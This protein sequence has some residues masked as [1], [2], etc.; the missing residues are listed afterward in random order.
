MAVRS[1]GRH[2]TRFGQLA[3]AGLA[4]RPVSEL[5]F[6]VMST[7]QDLPMLDRLLDALGRDGREFEL[8]CRWFLQNDPEFAAEYQHVWLWAEWPGRWGPDRGIDLVAQTFAGRIDAVQAKHYA[9]DHSVT[10][11]DLDTFLSESNRAGVGARLLIASTDLIAR[12]AREV[13]AEQEKPVSTCLLSRLRE[14]AVRWP[15]SIG[16]LVPAP[17]PATQPHAHQ[18]IA[19][20][21][22]DRWAETTNARGRVIMACGTGKTLIE[23]WAAERL[24]A[25]HVLVLAPTIPLLRQFAREWCRHAVTRRQ[26]LRIC[27]DKAADDT[28]DII[29]GDE[30]SASRTT[31]PAE[32]AE[33]LRQPAPQLVL[34]TYDSSPVLAEAL[35]SVTEFSFDLAI[36]DEAHRCA[37]LE[38]SRH[39]T[40]LEENAIRA[41]RRLFFTATPT[42]Y[43]TRDK[44]RAAHKNVRLA[45]MD[46]RTRFGPVIHHLSFAD[47]IAQ[48]LLCRYQVAVIPI[49]DDEVH[50]LIRRR[51]IVTADGDQK[52]EA[53][54]LATQIACARAMRRFGCRRIVAFHPS[55]ADSKRFSDHFPT[56]AGL[57]PEQERPPGPIWSQHIDGAGMPYAKRMRLLEHFQRE[58]PAEYRLLS[59]VRL[60][61]EGVN[62]P[63]I[64]AIAFVDTNRGQASVIQA[65]GRAVRRAPGKTLG[66][67]VL[68]IV[69]RRDESFDAALARSE[70]RSIVN[71]LGALRSHDSDIIKSLDDLRFNV[72]PGDH[73]PA[74][75]GRFVIDAPLHVGEEF[76]EAVDVALNGALGIA[77]Q[78]S[79]RHRE[80]R[81]QALVVE[82]PKP[83]AETELLE[84]AVSKLMVG[85]RWDLLTEVPADEKVG[86][87]MQACWI[88]LMR[89]WANG[90]LDHHGRTAIAR[91]VSW[92]ACDL[93]QYPR[94]R[95]E[96][97]RLTDA[98]VPE[99]IATHC[100]RNGRYADKFGVLAYQESYEL[101]A[102]LTAIQSLITHAAMSPQMRFRYLLPAVR[103]LAVAVRAAA[104]ASGLGP[105]E[106]RPWKSAAMIGFIYELEHAHAGSFTLDRPTEPL[107]ATEI[108]VAHHLGRRQAESFAPLARRMRAY[109]FS[110]DEEAVQGRLADEALMSPDERLDALG[111]DIYLLARV[112][113]D[114][115][116]HAFK[117]A[118]KDTFR[119]RHKLRRDLL[120]RSLREIER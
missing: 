19:L 12:S 23:I 74:A 40:I 95:R 2:A 90:T 61:T 69:L 106:Q 88:E 72:E 44:A 98:D 29:R 41:R 102:S 50:E 47:A 118:M 7:A 3:D 54:V 71:V 60:L 119:E 114:S 33:R 57:L 31:D 20:D 4:L 111:W 68:P 11:R 105:W 76:A 79:T 113:G 45:S 48:G 66:T 83:L 89:R 116:E 97:A 92:L 64:D 103:R 34:C 81:T 82:G 120:T 9:A 110:R 38:G 46:D 78:R 104:D 91:S 58:D 85:G 86:F 27:S 32:I 37:G 52:L 49:E 100:R 56:A 24:Q 112:R 80:T 14:S 39:K 53:A 94:Q 73:R 51:C 18:L 35:Q 75:H 36:A 109:R 87:P 26:M 70:H 55:I 13:M 6:D 43:G 63:E 115:S 42:V 62:V 65:I 30:L 77:A 25:R 16:E 5:M 8:L 15:G 117:L 22:I 101:V 93:D 96:M 99:Q 108:P 28:E 10:K 1:D 17:L 84:I 67:I 21:A 59:N 107:T